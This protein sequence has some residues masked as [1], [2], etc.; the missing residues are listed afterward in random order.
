MK[1]SCDT[2]QK[3]CQRESKTKW[4]KFLYYVRKLKFESKRESGR[5]REREREVEREGERGREKE[6]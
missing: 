2:R 1:E 5:E 4:K 3:K 6:R